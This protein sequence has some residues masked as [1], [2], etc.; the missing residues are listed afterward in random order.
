MEEG[1]RGGLSDAWFM[2]N[3]PNFLSHFQGFSVAFFNYIE[4]KI[5]Y[6]QLPYNIN[7]VFWDS[8]VLLEEVT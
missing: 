4:Q 6:R 2:A 1:N 5:K 7:D 3:R 8:D